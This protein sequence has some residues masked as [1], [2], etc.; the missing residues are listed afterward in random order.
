M[1]A[2]TCYKKAITILE[3]GPQVDQEQC[4]GCGLCVEKCPK[5][6]FVLEPRETIFDRQTGKIVN[7]P[8]LV[9]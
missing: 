2:Q 8:S 5:K 9:Q 7:L 6:I 1:P 4:L 3:A